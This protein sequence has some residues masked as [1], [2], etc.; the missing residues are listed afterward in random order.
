MAKDTKKDYVKKFTKDNNEIANK[1][2]MNHV[3]ICKFYQ[4][5]I[6]R[7][8]SP[9]E[10]EFLTWFQRKYEKVIDNYNLPNFS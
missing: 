1:N 2:S 10:D 4:D 8:T 7:M 5:K 6:T 3:K 9:G